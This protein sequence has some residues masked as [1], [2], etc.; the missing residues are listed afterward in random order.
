MSITRLYVE[1]TDTLA[2]QARKKRLAHDKNLPTC[3]LYGAIALR[4]HTPSKNG[5][6][7]QRLELNRQHGQYGI[8]W[9]LKFLDSTTYK[10]SITNLF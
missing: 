2:G 10:A 7:F 9:L 6:W 4:E 3:Q 5:I 1:L 8:L